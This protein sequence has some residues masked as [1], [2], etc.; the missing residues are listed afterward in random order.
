M[1]D[2]TAYFL[3]PD[4]Q[5]V[6]FIHRFVDVTKWWIIYPVVI[7]HSACWLGLKL[8]ILRFA[9]NLVLRQ[10]ARR[11]SRKDGAPDSNHPRRL[12]HKL[13][14]SVYN[15][16]RK[17]AHGK[18]V[19]SAFLFWLAAVPL[20]QKIGIAIVGIG[21]SRFGWR[22]AGALLLGTAVQVGLFCLLYTFYGKE[23]AEQL[24]YWVMLSLGIIM[25]IGW[26]LKNGRSS[27]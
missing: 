23:T 16:A 14:H 7:L 26:L 22:G 9:T 6:I 3:F 27:L 19:T 13:V 4:W 11:Q 21:W 8:G 2:L 24:M 20:S 10:I 25:L 17:V 1:F 12:F 15:G 5:F 18:S